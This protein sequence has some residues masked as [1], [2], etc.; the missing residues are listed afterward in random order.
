[1]ADA[2]C[3]E[4]GFQK[5]NPHLTVAFWM[6]MEGSKRG[7]AKMMDPLSVWRKDSDNSPVYAESTPPEVDRVLRRL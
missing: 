1:M 2:I 6:L 3:D 4:A 5:L 7:L